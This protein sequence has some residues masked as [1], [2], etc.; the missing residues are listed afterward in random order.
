MPDN[1]QSIGKAVDQD[2]QVDAIIRHDLHATT[3]VVW[4]GY[5]GSNKYGWW[6]EC[7]WQDKKFCESKTVE[8]KIYT[9]YAEE[10]LTIAID[11][12]LEVINTF[13]L[14]LWDKFSLY[15]KDD[16]ENKE[17][18]PPKSWKQILQEE[19]RKRH[20]ETYSD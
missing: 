13:G 3:M 5:S 10:T 8:G 2:G 15:Y 16:G 6:A 1:N 4:Y 7:H 11:A 19:A 20:C 18:P 14:K 12:I 9:R 17:Y